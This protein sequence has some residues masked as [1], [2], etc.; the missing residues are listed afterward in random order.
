MMHE[1][2]K[3]DEKQILTQFLTQKPLGLT[4]PDRAIADQRSFAGRSSGAAATRQDCGPAAGHRLQS[5]ARWAAALMR[6]PWVVQ[7]SCDGRIAVPV[8][9]T[10][11]ARVWRKWGTR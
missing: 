2:E 4:A 11:A 1:K 7:P 9:T 8:S 5:L 6:R 10:V 3:C